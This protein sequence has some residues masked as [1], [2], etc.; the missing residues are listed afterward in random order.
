MAKQKKPK[1]WAEEIAE[2][3]DPAPKGTASTLSLFEPLHLTVA[4]FDP[5]GP[6]NQ[7]SSVEDSEDDINEAPEH[8][9]EV[10]YAH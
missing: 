9:V 2:L 3:D 5:E 7:A 10:E 6:D 1:T 4:D 8:Y